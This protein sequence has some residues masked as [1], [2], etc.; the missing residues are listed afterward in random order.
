MIDLKSIFPKISY[1]FISQIVAA[2]FAVFALAITLIPIDITSKGDGRTI[3]SSTIQTIQATEQAA[4]TK[5]YVKENQ[6]VNKG[7]L[8][9][10]LDTAMLENELQ[11]LEHTRSILLLTSERIKAIL[12]NRNPV[13]SGISKDE[14][15]INSAI[16]IYEQ[17]KNTF[18]AKRS[19]IINQIKTKQEEENTI[20][21]SIE[22]FQ[23]LAATAKDYLDRL[24]KLIDKKVLAEMSKYDIQKQYI[25]ASSHLQ[26]QKNALEAAK[27]TRVAHEK[28][29]ETAIFDFERTNRLQLQENLKNIDTLEK[30]IKNIKERIKKMKIHATIDGVVFNVAVHENSVV[31]A[32]QTIAQLSPKDDAVEV[33]AVMN[34]A[35]CGLIEVGNEA[36]VKLAA[37]PY[38]VYGTIEGIVESLSPVSAN[39]LTKQ[40]GIKV[41]IKLKTQQIKTEKNAMNLMPLMSLEVALNVSKTSIAKYLLMYLGKRG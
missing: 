39:E 15:L 34:K 18:L 17:E 22:L 28:K 33:E 26:M 35:N 7:E 21:Q 20:K 4:I 27:N 9:F 37:F 29:L 8:L 38:Q 40:S 30:D 25:D 23:K 5:I 11:N 32:S 3:V 41:R 12:E 24:T 36:I 10:E 14:L 31:G 1:K 19:C 16:N 2:V 13:F 6:H